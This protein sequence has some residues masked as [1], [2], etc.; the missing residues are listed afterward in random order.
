MGYWKNTR[1]FPTA[2]EALALKLIEAAECKEGGNVLEV[3]HGCGDS[4]L[5]H[6]EHPSVPRPTRLVGIT[7]QHKH[8]LRSLKRTNQRNPNSVDV[9]L[10]EGDA[11]YRTPF[12]AD[13][14]SPFPHPLDTKH[15]KNTY[16][17]V[18][19]LDCAYHFDTRRLFL[20]QAHICL[21]AGRR[22]ALGDLCFLP[23]SL[24][25]AT[26]FLVALT[27]SI[28]RKNI[29]TTEE[30]IAILRDIGYVDVKM[31]DITSDVFPGFIGFLKG[32]GFAFNVVASQFERL[33]S[34]GMRFVIVSAAKSSSDAST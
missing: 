33:V 31:E 13:Q 20:E 4:L 27:G 9:R 12:H 19:A 22:I 34:H 21:A 14:Q 2:C 1:D 6:L 8:Y 28:P 11:I 23:G 10:A 15:S 25:L 18:L 7:S 30:Y 32:R 24:S 26:R 29:I 17:S 16:D 3:G 5:L